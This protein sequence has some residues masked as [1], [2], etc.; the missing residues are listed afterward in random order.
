MCFA[1][2]K[3]LRYKVYLIDDDG[4]SIEIEAEGN[5]MTEVLAEINDERKKRGLGEES[6]MSMERCV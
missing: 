1:C 3:K 6:I 2:E 5:S 4:L